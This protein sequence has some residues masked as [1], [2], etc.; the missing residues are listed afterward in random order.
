MECLQ[1]SELGGVRVRINLKR[2]IDENGILK[3]EITAGSL[4]EI[5]FTLQLYSHGKPQGAPQCS[6]FFIPKHLFDE[7]IIFSFLYQD[8]TLDSKVAISVW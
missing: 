6:N 2:I 4:H 1:V 3:Q 7:P 5:H 8:L